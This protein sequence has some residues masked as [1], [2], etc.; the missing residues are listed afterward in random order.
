M[1]AAELSRQSKGADVIEERRA[2]A[3]QPTPFPCPTARAE[4]L[5]KHPPVLDLIHNDPLGQS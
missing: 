3:P 1:I 4:L 5:G 2:I